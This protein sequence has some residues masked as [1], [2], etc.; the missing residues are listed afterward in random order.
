[1]KT[2]TAVLLLICALLA[3]SSTAGARTSQAK[4][5]TITIESW[6]QATPSATGLSGTVKACF[7]LSG[8]LSDQGGG[9][10]WTDAASYTDKSAP[11]A[12]CGSARPVGGFVLVPPLASATLYAVHTL[13]GKKG[14][15][16]IT[17]AGVY[18][19]ATAFMGSGT[20]VITGGT[21]TYSGL[22]GEGTWSADA[23]TF[24]Y[25]RHTET[26]TVH[27]TSGS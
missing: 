24:P 7:R 10:A 15:I 18:D 4:S 1:M 12:Q 25:I 16:F 19:L 6:L 11:T 8:A 13:T 20:W 27:L 21:G 17:F 14:R 9:P 26:G 23:S 22:E 5:G 2:A 3:V